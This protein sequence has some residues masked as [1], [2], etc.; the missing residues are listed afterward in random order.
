VSLPVRPAVDRVDA[1][2]VQDHEAAVERP[3]A[4]RQQ[5]LRPRSGDE[6]PEEEQGTYKNG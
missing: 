6:T 5:R 3:A 4:R 1:L 2:P